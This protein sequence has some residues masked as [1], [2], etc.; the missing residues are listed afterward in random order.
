ML[1]L[2]GVLL[3][4]AVLALTGCS[5]GSNAGMATLRG[6]IR[7]AE[8]SPRLV[9]LQSGVKYL[10]VKHEKREALMVWIG[11]ETSAMGD[12]S[13]W[14]SADGVILRLSK[15]GQ[16]LGV[17]ET[18]R[19]WRTVSKT[20]FTPEK[21]DKNK[22]TLVETTD[23]QPGYRL[24]VQRPV[25][26]SKIDA[27]SDDGLWFVKAADLEW[28]QKLDSSTGQKI[29]AVGRHPTNLDHVAGY[30]C[31]ASDW[32]LRWQSWPIDSQELPL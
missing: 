25:D 6:E 17:A 16:L 28:T 13:V 31:I 5:L 12:V 23:L 27:P 2:I 3:A 22:K 20:P 30:R 26:V 14:V 9:P 8:P 7:S 4:A 24:G 32:C 29:G 1:H 15:T 21:P 10:L 11:N 18:T 19:H